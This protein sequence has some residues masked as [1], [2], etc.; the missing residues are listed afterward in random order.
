MI[1]IPIRS[2]LSSGRTMDDQHIREWG[3]AGHRVGASDRQRLR[4]LLRFVST[5]LDAASRGT[6]VDL[7]YDVR[8]FTHPSPVFYLDGKPLPIGDD[9]MAS[10]ADVR[11]MHAY[12]RQTVAAFTHAGAAAFVYQPQGHRWELHPATEDTPARVV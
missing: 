8:Y 2:V 5:D 1:P 11:E 3:L 12:A 6:L 10:E 4:W 7:R 9:A